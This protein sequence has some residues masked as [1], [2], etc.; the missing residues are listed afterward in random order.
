MKGI[1]PYRNVLFVLFK[2]KLGSGGSSM[3]K[4]LALIL[5]LL[6]MC[7]ALVACSHEEFSA[8]TRTE[9]EYVSEWM[10]LKYTLNDNMQMAADEEL[11]ALMGITD[12]D[13]DID[14]SSLN[15]V[16]ELLATNTITNN[17]ITI[18]VDKPA[19]DYS[20][21]EYC[22]EMMS[23]LKALDDFTSGE[24]K[25]S[26]IAGVDFFEIDY[27]FSM[28]GTSFKQACFLKKM[29]DRIVV[30]TLTFGNEEGKQMLLSGFS[31]ID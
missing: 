24:L 29:G 2:M 8:G 31:K 13:K 9:K 14:Y 15:A 28:S 5:A 11:N 26:E 10:G 17:N 20:E 1:N 25:G 12:S 30:I 22:E 16:Y 27:S 3:K 7:T 21:E 6:L 19:I 4:R 18:M 23:Q